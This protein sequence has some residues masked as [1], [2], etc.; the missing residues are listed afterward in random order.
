MKNKMDDLRNHLFET[1]ENLR[2][3]SKTVDLDR[4]KMVNEVAKTLIDSARVEVAMLNV[5]GGNG[6]GFIVQDKPAPA[7]IARLA[8]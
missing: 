8:R 1:L 4:A 6:S 3:T 2:D 7:Q 5:V